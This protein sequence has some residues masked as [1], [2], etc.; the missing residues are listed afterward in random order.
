MI[1]YVT[2]TMMYLAFLFV[3]CF[4]FFVFVFVLFFFVLVLA[5]DYDSQLQ[6]LNSRFSEYV[7][8]LL[9]LTLVLDLR[10]GR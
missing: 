8:K 5:I 9:T 1:M 2:K 6:S 4:V 10:R 3:F 7:V